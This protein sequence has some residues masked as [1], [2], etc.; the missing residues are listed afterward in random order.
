MEPDFLTSRCFFSKLSEFLDL[1][2]GTWF[3]FS[4][5]GPKLFF[6]NNILTLL[7]LLNNLLTKLIYIILCK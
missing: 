6:L 2:V 1:T 3:V 4:L 7:L 5:T